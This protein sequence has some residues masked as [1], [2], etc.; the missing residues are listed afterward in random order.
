MVNDDLWLLARQFLARA[1]A[2]G[3]VVV[4]G[5]EALALVDLGQPALGVVLEAPALLVVFEAPA[6][7]VVFEAPALMVTEGVAGGI[8]A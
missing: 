1:L 3:V 4:D 7:L 6:L 2:L 5:H 8:E